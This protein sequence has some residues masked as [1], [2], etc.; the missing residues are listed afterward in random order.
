MQRA[1]KN[2]R[3]SKSEKGY[4]LIELVVVFVILGFLLTATLPL[5]ESY[6]QRNAVSET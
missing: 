2:T 5:Y 6:K 4:I 1:I 3:N